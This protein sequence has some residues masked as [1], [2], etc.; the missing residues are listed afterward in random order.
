MNTQALIDHLKMGCPM[1]ANIVREIIKRL[2]VINAEEHTGRD[3]T[4]Q[5]VSQIQ[6]PRELRK[7]NQNVPDV[8]QKRTKP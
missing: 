3:D 2:E 1:T 7:R 8:R 5:R 4:L 6:V